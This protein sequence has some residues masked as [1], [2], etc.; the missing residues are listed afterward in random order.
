[1]DGLHSETELV[2]LALNILDDCRFE[3]LTLLEDLFRGHAADDDAC[4]ALDDALDNLLDMVTTWARCCSHTIAASQNF[5]VLGKRLQVIVRTDGED[6]RKREVQLLNGH[7]LQGDL[8]VKGADGDL[9][10]FLPWQDPS[11][12][13]DLDVTY[14][15]A[16]DDEVRVC[17]G[18]VVPHDADDV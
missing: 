6:G 12:L 14:T 17:V 15:A 11:L 5:G 7:G 8:E 2:Q 3:D 16:S 1:M 13:D 9:A 18:D 4:L 10:A